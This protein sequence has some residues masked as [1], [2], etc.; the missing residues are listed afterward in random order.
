MKLSSEIIVKE[1][2]HN[3]QKLFEPE[4]K[5]FDN[6]R[7]S[8]EL[9]KN[10]DEL[11]FKISAEDSTALKAVLNSITKLLSVYEKTKSVVKE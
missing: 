10:K 3:I 6:Q 5:I 1:D 8:Y 11:V 9:K 2:I 4:E 7:A